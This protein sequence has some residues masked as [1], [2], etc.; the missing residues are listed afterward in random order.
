LI[1]ESFHNSVK[2][3]VDID[4]ISVPVPTELAAYDDPGLQILD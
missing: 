1:D 4:P 2:E 3:G